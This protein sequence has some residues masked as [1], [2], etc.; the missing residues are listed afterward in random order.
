MA[1]PVVTFMCDQKTT[2]TVEV[3]DRR[4]VSSLFIYLDK[5]KT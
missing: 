4:V 2:V 1:S 5:Y 3:R